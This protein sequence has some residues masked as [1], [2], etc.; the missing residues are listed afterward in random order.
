MASTAS[1]TVGKLVDVPR[2]L[3]ESTGVA[4]RVA[5]LRAGEQLAFSGVWGSVRAVFAAALARRVPHILMLLPEAAHADT[6]AGDA[7]A[8][9]LVNSLSLPLSS[10]SVSASSIRDEDYAERL[11]VLQQ[12]LRRDADLDEPLLVTTT[13]CRT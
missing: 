10:G 8:F 4:A 7:I 9:G 5:S 12:L 13:S 3:D 1:T 11:Q 6:V 2:L